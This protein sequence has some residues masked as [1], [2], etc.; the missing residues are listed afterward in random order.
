MGTPRLHRREPDI[1]LASMAVFFFLAFSVRLRSERPRALARTDVT[2]KPETSTKYFI[3]M[4]LA[5]IYAV[6]SRMYG[7]N[8]RERERE[9]DTFHKRMPHNVENNIQPRPSLRGT[10][11]T[12]SCIL[13]TTCAVQTFRRRLFSPP[14]RWVCHL[15][16]YEVPH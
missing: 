12:A 1:S 9:R 11:E 8:E 5:D 6:T 14:P 15:A 7:R 4:C 10:C 16:P 3:R 2:P 13:V